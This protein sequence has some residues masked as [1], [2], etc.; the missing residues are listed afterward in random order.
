MILLRVSLGTRRALDYMDG[1]LPEYQKK[2]T[3]APVTPRA[4][5][6]FNIRTGIS[7]QSGECSGIGANAGLAQ[8]IRP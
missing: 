4:V 1:P 8:G 5:R 7:L 6:E 3:D 2:S